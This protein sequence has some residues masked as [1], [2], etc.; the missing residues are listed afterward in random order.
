MQNFSGTA[1]MLSVASRAN[2]RT[3]ALKRIG[4]TLLCCAMFA[5]MAVAIVA[6]TLYGDQLRHDRIVEASATQRG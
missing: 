3:C 2:R 1:A 6:V 5:T 4:S